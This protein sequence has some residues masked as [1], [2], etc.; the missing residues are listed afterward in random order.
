MKKSKKETVEVKTPETIT[1]RMT[2]S[3]STFVS[4]EPITLQISEYPELQGKSEDEIKE[5]IMDNAWEMKSPY[6]WADSL[7]DALSQMDTVRE[8]ITDD[9]SEIYFD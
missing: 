5:H 3:Y 7:A 9:S 2:E 4:R 8:K 1:L 6:D